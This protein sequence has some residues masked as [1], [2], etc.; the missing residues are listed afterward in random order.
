M[1]TELRNVGGGL[2]QQLQGLRINEAA[3]AAAPQDQQCRAENHT[4]RLYYHEGRF[5]RIT[6]DFEF[7]KKCSLR[8]I[9]F[10]FHLHSTVDN[11]PPLKTLDNIS[12]R[13]IRRGKQVLA[14][15]RYL[16]A[17]LDVEA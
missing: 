8:D 15:L 14:D 2:I 6:P 16:M 5:I 12:M 4:V 10:R 3:A 17:V 9:F 1:I 11:I 7:P 13:H